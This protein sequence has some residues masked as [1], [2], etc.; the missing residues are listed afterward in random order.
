MPIS[1]SSAYAAVVAP[2][3]PTSSWVVAT[4][5]ISAACVADGSQGFNHYEGRSGG[6]RE[7][8]KRRYP[9][10]RSVVRAIVTMS[11]I[12]TCALTSS[13]G[14]PKS[15]KNSSISAPC[16]FLRASAGEWVSRR[17]S[18]PPAA[19]GRRSRGHAP[20]GLPSCA[21]PTRRRA[22]GAGNFVV[23]KLDQKADLV[24]VRGQHDARSAGSLFDGNHIA[25][26]IYPDFVG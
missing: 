8:W 21:G 11:P 24:G 12:S 9:P 6:R 23:N 18:A 5:M 25:D 16:P 26:G 2:R 15:T 3:R 10:M 22:G 19:T 17:A 7:T 1:G 14:S 13:T 4:A 20:A